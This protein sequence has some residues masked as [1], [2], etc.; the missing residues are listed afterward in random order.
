MD[1]G[2]S[3]LNIADRSVCSAGQR[4]PNA[5][6]NL[7]TFRAFKCVCLSVGVLGGSEQMSRC[8]GCSSCRLFV[9]TVVLQSH[10]SGS[11]GL[12]SIIAIGVACTDVQ[13]CLVPFSVEHSYYHSLYVFVVVY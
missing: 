13:V 12:V 2:G 4:R 1:V 10:L 8:A 9:V 7:R 3:A 11:I 5:R 6:Q